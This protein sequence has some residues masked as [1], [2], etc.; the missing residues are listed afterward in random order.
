[1]AAETHRR[2]RRGHLEDDE[3]QVKTFKVERERSKKETLS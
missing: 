2:V 3:S 1:M